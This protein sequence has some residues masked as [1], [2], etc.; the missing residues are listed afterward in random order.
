MQLG[1]NPS[2]EE[3]KDMILEI[4]KENK[5][6]IDLDDFLNLISL[7]THQSS[8]QSPA[9]A[10]SLSETLHEATEDDMR[11]AFR[12]FDRDGDGFINETELLLTLLGLGE[13]NINEERVRQL[14]FEADDDKDGKLCYSEFIKYLGVNPRPVAP[15]E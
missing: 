12:V 11:D 7:K 15:G 4:D 13:P 6:C 1:Q 3:L 10:L 8:S 5:G 14:I 2:E 9:P